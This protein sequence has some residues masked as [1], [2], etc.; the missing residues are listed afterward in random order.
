MIFYYIFFQNSSLDGL[1]NIFTDSDVI[2]KYLPPDVHSTVVDKITKLC[3]NFS[4]WT[5]LPIT[6]ICFGKVVQ[7]YSFILQ[8]LNNKEILQVFIW[9][10]VWWFMMFNVTFNNISVI[11]WRSVLLMEQTEVP[12]GNHWHTLSHNVVSSTP[13]HE[14]GFELTT[15]V[16]IGTDCTGSWKSNYYTITS[17][18]VPYMILEFYF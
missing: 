8:H 14:R 5:V 9:Y 4:D 18:T 6:R 17:T 2:D 7:L 3:N 16:V 12:R 11:S 10:W 15:S 13:R 1:L